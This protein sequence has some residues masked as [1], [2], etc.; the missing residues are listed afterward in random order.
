MAPPMPST[1]ASASPAAATAATADPLAVL[2]SLSHHA[3]YG[4]P[5]SRAVEPA[6]T[7]APA[8]PSSLPTPPTLFGLHEAA[9]AAAADETAHAADAGHAPRDLHEA[10]AASR[11]VGHD[12]VAAMLM[13]PAHAHRLMHPVSG[14]PAAGHPALL[15]HPAAMRAA[16]GD[17]SDDSDDSAFDPQD[18]ANA[19]GLPSALSGTSATRG[20]GPAA[21]AADAA[22]GRAP[23][24]PPPPPPPPQITR[25]GRI[26]K[27]TTP[28]EPAT[29]PT[30]ATSATGRRGGRGR[31]GGNAGASGSAK[32]R[33]WPHDG[34]PAPASAPAGLVAPDAFADLALGFLD[35]DDAPP[36]APAARRGPG[37]PR[38]AKNGTGRPRGRPPKHE[39]ETRRSASATPADD[40]AAAA[41]DDALGPYADPDMFCSLCLL[42]DSKK[43]N[44]IVLC[45]MCNTPYHQACHPGGPVP[46][47][48]VANPW[49]AWFCRRCEGRPGKELIVA[50]RARAEQAERRLAAKRARKRKSGTAPS[51]ASASPASAAAIPPP[52]KRARGTRTAAAAAA[53]TTRPASPLPGM[54]TDLCI[55]CHRLRPPTVRA[56]P[57]PEDTP[58]ATVAAAVAD[59]VLSSAQRHP[60]ASPARAPP[61]PVPSAPGLAKGE[62]VSAPTAAAAAAA[63]P[64]DPVTTGAPASMNAAHDEVDD[65]S[66][67]TP[68]IDLDAG[69][70]GGDAHYETVNLADY[71]T[72]AP[73]DASTAPAPTE[74]AASA[75]PDDESVTKADG[76]ASLDADGEADEVE[77]DRRSMTTTATTATGLRAD[78]VDTVKVE[79]DGAP[80][81]TAGIRTPASLATTLLTKMCQPCHDHMHGTWNAVQR[82]PDALIRLL[83]FE[84]A[85][86]HPEV[87]VLF[88]TPAAP[89]TT[90]AA[91]APADAAHARAEE[92]APLTLEDLVAYSARPKTRARGYPPHI[93]T[94]PAPV[95]IVTVPAPA[96]ATATEASAAGALPL[97]QEAAALASAAAAATVASA[98]ESWAHRAPVGAASDTPGL[99][100]LSSTTT[101]TAAPPTP[102]LLSPAVRRG[103]PYGAISARRHFAAHFGTYEDLMIE[104]L[105]SL[106]QPQGSKPRDIFK[107]MAQKHPGLPD[108]FKQSAA[109]ALLK[110]LGRGRF[111]RAHRGAYLV[112]YAYQAKSEPRR[113]TAT[114]SAVSS[115]AVSSPASPAPRTAGSMTASASP[116]P[117]GAATPT[118]PSSAAAVMPAAAPATL[119]D[120]TAAHTH[121][122]PPPLPAAPLSHA[123]LPPATTAPTPAAASPALAMK[124]EPA[125]QPPPPSPPRP[126]ATP[127]VS[128][129]PG[130]VPHPLAPAT[131]NALGVMAG[132]ADAMAAAA[133]SALDA[134]LFGDAVA[135]RGAD[136]AQTMKTLL[137]MHLAA[138]MDAVASLHAA[139][140]ALANGGRGAAGGMPGG[141]PEPAPDVGDP[142]MMANEFTIDSYFSDGDAATHPHHPAHGPVDP[143]AANY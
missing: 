96:T 3:P 74:G 21:D 2:A 139:V 26:S 132:A 86:R 84:T 94:V 90:A 77:T 27:P 118:A 62:P 44:E 39:S 123:P 31:G 54:A 120:T 137:P 64:A 112:N 113:A 87:A 76:D 116:G 57:V 11:R 130:L 7:Q 56:R 68:L 78:T 16:D 45:D 30:R 33:P 140:P 49:S 36:S 58:A 99:S 67:A 1:A 83:A 29:G 19:T 91:A 88:A 75:T 114:S 8:A 133:P 135:T 115:A 18:A 71:V 35:L 23:P 82:T 42:G 25:G 109:H 127:S 105:E 128:T 72:D 50:E 24:P 63:A 9:A 138:S 129:Q 125:S 13:H 98:A 131:M 141:G 85:V 32:G 53:A 101:S 38:G 65:P 55:V 48:V 122:P 108:N 93:V 102:A 69:L 15:P 20:V 89:T 12:A 46:D 95:T 60:S 134:A 80:P 106:G 34:A 121:A 73:L 110:A 117:S 119:A 66:D 22:V 52:T 59:A 17:A 43:G 28:F 4:P 47:S 111:L 142:L 97:A 100:Q 143:E 124:P 41:D 40:D 92:R 70:G 51:S 103:S 37:R 14:S 6:A 81:S 61:R 126:S 5:P 107:A 104:A 136:V 79:H 10:M